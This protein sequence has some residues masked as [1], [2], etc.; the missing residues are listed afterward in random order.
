MSAGLERSLR[1]RNVISSPGE[2]RAG[3]ADAP[4]YASLAP[5]GLEEFMEDSDRMI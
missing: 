4:V 5:G 2:N 1:Y 3:S